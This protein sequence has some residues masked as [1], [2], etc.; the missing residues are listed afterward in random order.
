MMSVEMLSR[1][2][3]GVTIGFHYLF[4]ITTLGLT[5]FILI[6]ETLACFRKNE[7]CRRAS[8]FLTQLLGLVF[9]G[10]VATGI[11]LPVEIGANWARF[12]RCAG[13]VFGPMLSLEAMLAFALESA[14]LAV[15]LFGGNK[16][17]PRVRWFSALC[18]FLGSHFSAFLIVAA[19]SWMQTPAGY[20]VENGQVVL[21]SLRAAVLNP[22][23]H[24]RLLHVLTAAWLTGAFITC[25]IAAYYTARQLQAELARTLFAIAL[26]VA[27]LAALAQPMIGHFH[28]MNVAANVPEKVAAFEGVFQTTHG[29]PLYIFGVPD[30]ANRMV[31]VPVCIPGALSFLESGSFHSEVKGLNE[32][33][34]DRWPPVN[35]VFTCFHLMVMLGV[36][37]VAITGV[38][39]FLLWRGWLA[40][41]RWYLLLLPWL[42]VLPYLANEIGWGAA[43]MG[44]QPWVIHNVLRTSAAT[45]ANLPA[46]QVAIS[47]T[48]IATFYILIVALTLFFAGRMIRRGPDHSGEGRA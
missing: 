36:V 9:V 28:I 48:G 22:S 14:F 4:P 18:V 34:E 39:A 33:P 47:L 30:Q 10:G 6:F 21:T 24:L 19:N 40:E 46:W 45:S 26:P 37:M 43:E 13:S 42:A 5:L 11:M 32:F 2:Q 35:V 44:R 23:T 16:V 12:S 7:S 20:L 17:S 27:F 31:H 29:A 38:G 3:F 25:G 41:A 8:A 1:V 15:L